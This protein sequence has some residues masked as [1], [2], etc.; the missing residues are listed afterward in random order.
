M[1]IF[2]TGG[3]GMLGS[4]ILN[5]LNVSDVEVFSPHKSELDLNDF[6]AVRNYIAFHK[7]TLII[8]GA[9]LV[10][11]ISQNIKMPYE[12]CFVNLQIGM[13]VLHAAFLEGVTNLI[14]ISSANVYP[15]GDLGYAMNENDILSGRLN[16]NTEGYGLAKTCVLKLASYLSQQYGL[17]YKSLIPCNLYGQWDSFD[18]SKSHMIPGII[19]RLHE[20]KFNNVDSVEI[21]GDGS[22]RREF[23]FAEDLA[24]FIKNVS[25]HL[26]EL[27]LN[28][29]LAPETDFSVLEYNRIIAKVVGYQGE[30][31]FDETKPV[32]T[33]IKRL[34]TSLAESHGWCDTTSI[35]DGISKTYQY[36]LENEAS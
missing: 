29:N 27:P 10:G 5:V 12:Y 9:G 3:A 28:L 14:N 1:K 23:L 32:G 7:P 17:N 6:Q 31:H 18:V 8:H 24:L 21:W 13:N 35:M 20:A 16:S 15:D 34:D 4:N 33:K 2:L 11:G 25:E 36:F 22:A 30:F 26:A 19:R